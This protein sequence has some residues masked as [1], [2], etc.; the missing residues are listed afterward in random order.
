MRLIVTSCSPA[1]GSNR[2]KGIIVADSKR[3]QSWANPPIMDCVGCF[4]KVET[5]IVVCALSC[6]CFYRCRLLTLA[7]VILITCATALQSS[8]AA[9]FVG[10]TSL[11]LEKIMA[12]CGEREAK[13]LPRREKPFQRKHIWIKLWLVRWT[14]I[15]ADT[16]HQQA[17]DMK[18]SVTPT[19]SRFFLG[20]GGETAHKPRALKIN[21]SA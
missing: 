8:E 3:E 20:G 10:R 19:A 14:P 15:C 16:K 21:R 6:M 2:M 11:V 12:L 1:F 18:C 5:V 7:L 9:A 13:I 4:A 17:V